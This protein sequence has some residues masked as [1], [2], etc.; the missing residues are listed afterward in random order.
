MT[1]AKNKNIWIIGLATLAAA[2]LII[3][4]VA[5][6][7]KA[8]GGP[9]ITKENNTYTGRASTAPSYEDEFVERWK[10]VIRDDATCDG[11]IF[12]NNGEDADNLID[13]VYGSN[14]FTPADTDEIASFN[15]KY[16]CFN[17]LLTNGNWLQVGSQLELDER[18]GGGAA[19][20]L[21]RIDKSRK[22]RPQSLQ[23]PGANYGY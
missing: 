15:G 4:S 2:A 11:S 21:G 17:A 8:A 20:K 16:I 19:G 22:N 5:S 14:S 7:S 13:V 12:T 6:Y 10:Y 23:L 1:I 9:H 18:R 3:I